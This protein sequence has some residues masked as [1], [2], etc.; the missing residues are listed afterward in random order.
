MFV[1]T[2]FMTAPFSLFLKWNLNADTKGYVERCSFEQGLCSW[3]QSDL[4]SPGS[5]WS[6][7]RGDEAWP[8]LGPHRDHTLNSAAGTRLSPDS[9]RPLN[10]SHSVSACPLP[11][12]MG[13]YL[14]A[15]HYVIPPIGASRTSEI[16]S[17][18]LLPS[19]D[20][21]VG[22][23]WLCVLLADVL[24]CSTVHGTSCPIFSFGTTLILRGSDSTVCWGQ[25]FQSHGLASGWSAALL[26]WDSVIRRPLCSE[27]TI[28]VWR[29]S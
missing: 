11:H 9:W 12:L 8:T 4:D 17:R 18:T 23:L 5:T 3:V 20:C 6:R 22:I 28:S 21:T 7:H 2:I 16:V 1:C 19:S 27:L 13:S 29:V 24:I 15:G 25:R 26:A 10:E 14:H